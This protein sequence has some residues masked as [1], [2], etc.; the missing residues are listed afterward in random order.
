MSR[1]F[2]TWIYIRLPPQKSPAPAY[3]KKYYAPLIL[4]QVKKLYSALEPEYNATLIFY[5]EKI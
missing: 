1:D 3:N 5:I 4:P 2:E